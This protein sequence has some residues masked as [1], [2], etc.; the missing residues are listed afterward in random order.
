VV[1]DV[2]AEVGHR[3]RVERRE[4]HGVD[5]EPV[6]MIEVLLDAGQ[7][8]GRAPPGAGERPGIDLIEDGALPPGC[9]HG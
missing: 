3:R 4:P 2:V 7:V 5:A 9:V 1:G 6:E 8:A